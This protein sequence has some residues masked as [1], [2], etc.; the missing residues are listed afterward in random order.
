MMKACPR[1]KMTTKTN[2]KSCWL[3]IFAELC[4]ASS[5]FGCII[6]STRDLN[7]KNNENVFYIENLVRSYN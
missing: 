7:H 5:D 4:C 6:R 3:S 2:M 1:S